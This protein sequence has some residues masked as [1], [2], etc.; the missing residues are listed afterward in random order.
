MPPR[1][2]IDAQTR[3]N[4]QEEIQ[5]KQLEKDAVWVGDEQMDNPPEWLRDKIAV[6]E[7]HRL[8]TEFRKKQ[9]VSNLDYNN[10]G[11]YCN[12]FSTY[13]EIVNDLKE[14]DILP[15][16]QPNPLISLQLKY[17]EEMRKFAN[18]LGLTV[19]SRLQSGSNALNE[20][21]KKVGDDFGEI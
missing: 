19:Q 10:L 15:G 13:V 4:T 14:D 1:K 2:D 17:S 20:K 7:W 8:V 12:A 11:G 6:A 5:R 9:L 3:H 21:D 18:T 16:T